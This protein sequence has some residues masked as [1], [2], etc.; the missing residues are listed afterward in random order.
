MS[1]YVWGVLI[2]ILQ[3]K[4]LYGYLFTKRNKAVLK[5]FEENNI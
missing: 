3:M 5:R 2:M 4:T 1:C